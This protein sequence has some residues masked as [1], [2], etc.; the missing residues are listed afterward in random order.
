MV[1]GTHVTGGGG[2]GGKEKTGGGAVIVVVEGN[3]RKVTGS[4]AVTIPGAEEIGRPAL[5]EGQ[6]T[7]TVDIAVL[8]DTGRDC[9]T[10]Q[11][12][13]IPMV[14]RTEPVE[15]DTVVNVIDCAKVLPVKKRRAL[16]VASAMFFIVV[17]ARQRVCCWWTLRE[18]SS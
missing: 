10:L 7:E 18:S 12:A 13:G 1:P 2:E 14:L 6:M 11:K 4:E 9:I 16:V 3:G 15:I 8:I 17:D 5:Q